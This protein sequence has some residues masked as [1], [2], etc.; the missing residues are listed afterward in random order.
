[1]S[2]VDARIADVR[3]TAYR[4]PTEQPE[5]DGTLE[6]DAVTVVVVEV[7]AGGHT[8]LGYTYTDAAAASLITGTLAAPSRTETRWPPTARGGPWSAPSA[9][10]GGPASAPPPSRP[11]MSPCGTS[12]PSC[13]Q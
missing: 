10:S 3:A 6:W 13:W 5:S 2:T 11:S 8:G 12:R 4:V 9:I 1:M 7:D